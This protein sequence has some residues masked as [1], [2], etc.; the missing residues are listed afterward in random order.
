MKVV[1]RDKYCYSPHYSEHL[2]MWELKADRQSGIKV[3]ANISQTHMVSF[4]TS[5]KK[6]LAFSLV[7]LL[8]KQIQMYNY[9]H[10]HEVRENPHCK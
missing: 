6:G 9:P 1:M 7:T 3:A 5:R 10:A 4:D 8:I 2:V